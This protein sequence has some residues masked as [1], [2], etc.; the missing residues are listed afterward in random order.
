MMSTPATM[1]RAHRSLVSHGTNTAR[2]AAA[3]RNTTAADIPQRLS[4]LIALSPPPMGVEGAQG[5]EKRKPDHRHV[6][7]DVLGLEDALGEAVHVLDDAGLLD[8]RTERSLGRVREPAEKPESE[9]HP[10]G[11][12]PGD[13]LVLGGG[14]HEEPDGEEGGPDEEE[15]QV[16]GGDRAHSSRV[17]Q[18]TVAG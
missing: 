7:H 6:V 15:P 10:E 9:E 17:N 11:A 16:A 12:E 1:T 2:A 14:G 18:A 5:Q 8:D 4:R 13:D 3:S